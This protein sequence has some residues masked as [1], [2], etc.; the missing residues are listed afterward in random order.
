MWIRRVSL[1]AAAILGTSL[2]SPSVAGAN[3]KVCQNLD[4]S[5][6]RVVGSADQDGVHVESRLLGTS[7]CVQAF[8]SSRGVQNQL[9]VWVSRS[10]DYGKTWEELGHS[11]TGP[12]HL[13]LYKKTPGFLATTPGYEV[14]SCAANNAITVEPHSSGKAD[15]PDGEPNPGGLTN[16]GVHDEVGPT[17]CTSA[18]ESI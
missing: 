9:I 5:K 4:T 3:E 12:L 8:A 10:T 1:L 18:F 15:D 2:L 16:D 13:N 14:K 6:F 11:T 7:G 17:V